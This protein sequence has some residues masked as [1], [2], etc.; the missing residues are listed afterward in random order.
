MFRYTNR[1][2]TRPARES[3]MRCWGI[4]PSSGWA[5]MLVLLVALGCGR[6]RTNP[7]DPSFSGN[8]ALAPPGNVQAAG[9]IGQIT[10]QWNAV[11][12]NEL[13]GYGIWR[14]TSATEG[15]IRLTGEVADSLI[16]T[17]RTTFV[18]STVDLSVSR[19]F[20]YRITTVDRLERQSE[21]S[22]FVSAEALVDNR[23]PAQPADL[24]AVA[25][26]ASG[27]V[28]LNWNAPLSDAN[29]Q[30]LTGVNEYNVFRAKDSQ[31]SFVKIGTVSSLVT[32]FTDSSNLETDAVYF[33]RVSASDAESNESGRSTSAS[34]STGATGV[35]VPSGLRTTSKIGEIEISWNAVADP[36]LIGYLVLRS[37]DTQAAFLP[38][39]SDTLF[40]TAQTTYVDST[41]AVDQVVFY[42]VRAV[43]SD[44]ELGL[45]RS[46]A[47]AFV[48]GVSTV[49][50]AP[51]AAP[52]DVI[53]SL[54]END[55]K[56][57]SISWTAPDR[58]SGGG[59]LT[60]LSTYRVFRSREST[61]SFV[62]LGEIPATSE[63]FQDSTI[64]QLTVYFY[65]ISAVDGGGNVGPRSSSIN[66]ITKG[67]ARPTNIRISTGPQQLILTWN[68]NTEPELT[69]Y[70]VRRFLDPA[71]AEP[72]ATFSTAQT[73]FVDS[74]LVAGQTLS[75][76]V[77][78]IVTGGIQSEPSTFV[79]ATVE[80]Q[81]GTPTI[82]T[83]TGG[84]SR[85][86]I[87]WAANSEDEL[88]GYR[89]LRFRAP[90]ETVAEATFETVQTTYVDSPLT[91]G[92]TLIYRVQALG[93][94]G[95]ESQ[96][97]LFSAADVLSDTRAPATPTQLASQA[98]G[99]T[100]I[101]LTWK[102]PTLDSDG[103]TL[104]GL[105]GYRLYRAISAE[106]SG[107]VLLS[108]LGS[109]ATSF[110][111]TGLTVNTTYIY[112]VSALD[113]SGN[114]SSLSS[115]VTR[116]TES[117]S[118]V[119]APTNLTL[120]AAGDASSVT[121]SW[122]APASFT[123]FRVQRKQTGSDSSSGSFTTIASS[124]TGTSF[125]DTT[126]TSGLA[127]TYRVLTRLVNDFSDPSEEKTVV[128]P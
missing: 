116:T 101:K 120:V 44:P 23:P 117:T 108:A 21:L 78:A 95:I 29:G 56:L 43:A 118:G 19:V 9:G 77:V 64:D 66:V 106:S 127:Y 73:T 7:I 54:D 70:E 107:F 99:Q 48:D 26:V 85:A 20:F 71:D 5:M 57:I 17:G 125:V 81:L 3:Q 90:S 2:V 27:F 89:V 93:A 47:S 121:V 98:T 36:N 52:T 14:S 15:F 8:D 49:D 76:R 55:L 11:V 104:T 42:K 4:R 13:K 114:E 96:R 102:A 94:G 30:T 68:A 84:I 124:A 6:E 72:A 100:S 51:P 35:S 69:G 32:S 111:D 62:L 110:D 25:D 16:T 75:Y 113:E 97:S 87:T 22:T 65:A 63:S 46:S 119:T 31:D 112:R 80:S 59:E 50:E 28:T 12:S 38:V 83:A 79:S 18:D 60:G 40:T 74:P 91:A 37:T 126:I 41:I 58:D 34:I 105:S 123:D 115:S 82:V 10:L 92:D 67:A 86:T 109:S 39:T 61:S 122:T 33:Y 53:V 103:S 1:S 45:I 24:S 88:I 128:V